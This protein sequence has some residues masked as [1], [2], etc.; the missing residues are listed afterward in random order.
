VVEAHLICLDSPAEDGDD[1]RLRKL[2]DAWQALEVAKSLPEIK[3][4]RDIAAAIQRYAHERGYAL[5][6]QN[7]AAELKL[8]AERRAGVLLTDTV[9]PGRRKKLSN[10]SII[11]SLSELGVTLYQSATWQLEASVDPSTFDVWCATTKAAGKELASAG[12]IRLAKQ[13]RQAAAQQE[14]QRRGTVIALQGYGDFYTDFAALAARG[15]FQCLYVDPPWPYTNQATRASTAKH[16]P[17]LSLEALC[18]LPVAT[19]VA[20]QCH[21]HLWVTKAFFFDAPRI[22]AAWGFTFVNWLT[23]CKPQ[24]GLGNSYRNATELLVFG[25]RGKLPVQTHD[26]RDW[27]EERRGRHSEKPEIFRHIVEKLSPGPYLELFGRRRA[28]GWV[29]WG[30]ECEPQSGRMFRKT[31]YIKKI[32]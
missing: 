32:V 30:N 4:I 23:W 10:T 27:V 28:E 13:H 2:E 1:A 3:Q 22:L 17:T 8:R 11:S 7:D 6:V 14:A 25:T 29:V 5:A 18:A 26:Q 19:V 20:P 16:Y 24:M 12:L 31:D 15:P 9:H 21:L